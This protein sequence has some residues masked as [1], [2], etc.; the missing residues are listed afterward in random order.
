MSV[1][2][3]ME[4]VD[5]VSAPAKGVHKSL[6]HVDEKVEQL[7]KHSK[8]AH[9]TLGELAHGIEHA[10]KKAGKEFLEGLAEKFAVFSVGYELA[11]KFLETLVEIGAE[12]VHD[13]VGAANFGRSTR[14]VFD[15]LLG[16]SEKG[17]EAVEYLEQ[18][19]IAAGIGIEKSRDLVRTLSLSGFEGKNLN[20]VMNAAVDVE[21]LSGGRFQ[22]M[23]F[24]EAFGAL[25]TRGELSARMLAQFQSVLGEGGF[26]KLAKKLGFATHGFHQLQKQLEETPVS[27][28]RAEQAI[29]DV[30][31]EVSGG[32]LGHTQEQLGRELP[33]IWQRIQ[34]RMHI[35]LGQVGESP[36]WEH[37]LEIFSRLSEALDPATDSGK[38]FG[39]SLE[40][41]VGGV[42]ELFERMSKPGA[43]D[44]FID[45]LTRFADSAATVATA[46]ISI[47]E[48]IADLI[49][50]WNDVP[51]EV[52]FAINP[53]AETSKTLGGFY[54]D[55]VSWVKGAHDDQASY[56]GARYAEEQKK[57][58]ELAGQGL[59]EGV[60]T[61][62]DIHSPS[63]V[64]YRL[65]ANAGEGLRQGVQASTSSGGAGGRQLV[66]NL[67]VNVNGSAD[68][69]E[70]L[71]HQVAKVL[72]GELQPAFDSLLEQLGE[73]A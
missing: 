52:K 65:G 3:A 31:E 1:K 43:M 32:K 26:D 7:D 67:E 47:T 53:L 44:S 9:G 4:L 63:R 64:M 10:N 5:K 69:G 37:L 34:D 42:G 61:S 11:E 72:L 18:W 66:V 28:H 23:E 45:K 15:A 71:G 48:A 49:G 68:D 38:S 13:A 59:K 27:A 33:G 70:E 14:I 54:A 21:A 30:I 19:A 50:W 51:K 41:I 16:S 36:A 60:A 40:R 29:L 73:A 12:L 46:V 56:Q 22:A 20:V 2:W 55:A 17:N 8:H 6:E 25:Q 62:L 57:L 39:A 58:G 24:A 35:L